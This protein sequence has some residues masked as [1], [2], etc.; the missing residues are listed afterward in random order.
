MGGW[1]RGD[2]CLTFLFFLCI[3]LLCFLYIL[4]AKSAKAYC[5]NYKQQHHTH[6][7]EIKKILKLGKKSFGLFQK[8]LN[9]QFD[10]AL[11]TT[12]KQQSNS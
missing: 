9:S 1:R 4:Y 5:H 6:R 10:L 3:T 11:R 7:V 2:A 12:I 8:V